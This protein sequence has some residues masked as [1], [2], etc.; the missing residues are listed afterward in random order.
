MTDPAEIPEAR[1]MKKYFLDGHLFEGIQLRSFVRIDY[2][3]PQKLEKTTF[4]R[5]KGLAHATIL[6]QPIGTN[7]KL[8]KDEAEEMDRIIQERSRKTG[9]KLIRIEHN[10][11]EEED[12]PTVT[13]K[14]GKALEDPP[15]EICFSP[16]DG[17]KMLLCDGCDQGFH[18]FCLDPPMKSVPKDSWYCKKCQALNSKSC[19]IC[20]GTDNDDSMLLCDMCDEG[21]HTG[22]LDPPLEGIPDTIWLCPNC[23]VPEDQVN[24]FLNSVVNV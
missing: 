11:D 23:K 19:M 20:E 17:E 8:T 22:C 9:K 24:F 12:E 21:Y 15:C 6:R 13:S 18:T 2:L 14:P 3:L 5:H 4:L 7:F 16:D 1:G 10:D